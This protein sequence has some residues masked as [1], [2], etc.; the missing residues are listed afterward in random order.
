MVN[1]L[2]SFSGPRTI[3]SLTGGIDRAAHLLDRLS[4]GQTLRRSLVDRRDHVAGQH[5]GLGGGGVFDRGDDL[6]E[7]FLLR[8]PDAVRRIRPAGPAV[9]VVR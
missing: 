3:L 8:E 5:A 2:T 6:D 9:R 7:A 1:S 4:E